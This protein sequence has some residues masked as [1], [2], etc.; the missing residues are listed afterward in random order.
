MPQRP[1]IGNSPNMIHSSTKRTLGFVD[2]TELRNNETRCSSEKDLLTRSEEHNYTKYGQ[3]AGLLSHQHQP[4]VGLSTQPINS[5]CSNTNIKPREKSS[6][7]PQTAVPS[8]QLQSSIRDNENGQ[9]KV[10][11]DARLAEQR[12]QRHHRDVVHKSRS[13]TNAVTGVEDDKSHHLPDKTSGGHQMDVYSSQSELSDNTYVRAV[14]EA[15]QHCDS[16]VNTKWSF[17]DNKSNR[18]KNISK[19]QTARSMP[20]QIH[21]EGGVPMTKHLTCPRTCI[22]VPN[23]LQMAIP[24]IQTQS[25]DERGTP[26]SKGS[27]QHHSDEVYT[28]HSFTSDEPRRWAETSSAVDKEQGMGDVPAIRQ[29]KHSRRHRGASWN[30]QT[31]MDLSQVQPSNKSNAPGNRERLTNASGRGVVVSREGRNDVCT[32]YGGCKSLMEEKVSKQLRT[33][34]MSSR[35]QGGDHVPVA[36]F[37][38]RSRTH[39]KYPSGPQ[40]TVPSSQPQPSRGLSNPRYGEL[41][42]HP[43]DARYGRRS[44]TN[45]EYK[46]RLTKSSVR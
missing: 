19:R 28:K 33:H 10:Q 44:N 17:T 26:M 31:D 23:G 20:S 43:G 46:G 11:Q 41:K 9:R 7:G 18:E 13:Y 35:K 25:S 24:M 37:P 39:N 3:L 27:R 4:T 40:T 22:E 8:N 14:K 2:K 1:H 32:L 30:H 5:G 6:I 38:M 29:A 42:G 16:V 34:R 45:D 21:E 12:G 36:Q 15:K